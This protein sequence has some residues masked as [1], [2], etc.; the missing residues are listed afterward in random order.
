LFGI[1]D[2]FDDPS[3]HLAAKTT[4]LSLLASCPAHFP[5]PDQTLPSFL[6]SL[7]NTLSPNKKLSSH[8]DLVL[9]ALVAHAPLNPLFTSLSE[10]FHQELTQQPADDT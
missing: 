1:L 10:L 5:L 7:V 3:S 4:S 8:Y 9:T 2:H 6:S